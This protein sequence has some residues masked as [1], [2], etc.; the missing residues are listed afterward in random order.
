MPQSVATSGA[1]R[2]DRPAGSPTTTTGHTDIKETRALC[3]RTPSP[4]DLGPSTS[5]FAAISITVLTPSPGRP[6]PA[7]GVAYNIKKTN[8]VLR[9]SYAR[10]MESPFNENLILSGT[11]CNNPVVNAI[12]TVAQGFACT[13]A[14]LTP[15]FRNEFHA[16]LQQAFGK[17]FVLSGEYIW[18]YTHN[19]YDFN[20]FGTTPITLPIEWHNSKIPGFAVR[21]SVPDYP[22]F[23]GVYRD[24]PR[25][26]ALLPADRQR[27]RA[28]RS[29]RAYSASTTTKISTRPRTCNISRSS[30]GRGSASTGDMTAAWWP[31][32]C[33]ALRQRSTCAVFRRPLPTA[34]S[35][36]TFQ[37]AISAIDE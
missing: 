26:R 14:P 36:P 37:R 7:C 35:T 17:Y 25:R 31:A 15:G 6:S 8:T 28:S 12:M 18:K 9:I 4:R 20:V 23:D 3:A 10:T 19:A 29:R 5:G 13:S 32:R 27:N 22:R 16:G 21:G 24:V 33:P 34:G 1:L 30:A 2:P 11:G